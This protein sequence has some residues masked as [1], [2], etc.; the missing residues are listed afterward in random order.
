MDEN[1]KRELIMEHYQNPLNRKIIEDPSYIKVN[2]ANQSC[3]DNLDLYIKVEDNV[4]KDIAFSGEACAISISSTSIMIENLIGK[5]VEE[6]V[7][8]INNFENMINEKEYNEDVLKTALVYDNIYKQN[9]R[10]SCAFLPYRGI[11]E[12]LAK[13]SK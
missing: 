4:I 5:T 8:Y 2:T 11:K 7:D 1:V 13:K 6:A 3:I 12:A 9:S 10:K